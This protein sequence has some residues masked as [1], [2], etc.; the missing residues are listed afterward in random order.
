[1][2]H[3]SQSLATP[4]RSRTRGLGG[5][6]ARERRTTS[7]SRNTCRCRT[8]RSWDDGHLESRALMLRVFLACRRPRRLP[9][10]ARRAGADRAAASGR[11]SRVSAAAAARTPGCSRTRP[12]ARFSLLPGG[13]GAEDVVRSER[14]VSSRVGGASVLDGTLRGAQRELRAAAARRARRACRT[15]TRCHRPRLQPSCARACVTGCCR[16]TTVGRRGRGAIRADL[17]R[18]LV[19]RPRRSRDAERPGVQ[20]RADRARRRAP[21]AIGCRPTTGGS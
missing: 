11:S 4:R 10:D 20:R 7:W 14:I 2:R 19:R 5:A 18:A 13:S 1:M 17:E 16:P 8:R 21:C 6:A 3:A 15:P 9:R 12:V